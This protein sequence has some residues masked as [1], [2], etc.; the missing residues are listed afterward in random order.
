M[1]PSEQHSVAPSTSHSES[2]GST[3]AARGMGRLRPSYSPAP[4]SMKRRGYDDALLR[5]R[6]PAPA[7]MEIVLLAV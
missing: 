7:A 4:T 1:K 5:Y 6:I 2:I 3:P